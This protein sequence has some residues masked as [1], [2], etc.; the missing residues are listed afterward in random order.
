MYHDFSTHISRSSSFK[1]LSNNRIMN[2]QMCTY[3]H[4]IYIVSLNPWNST[5]D[6]LKSTS[7]CVIVIDRTFGSAEL[8]GRTSAVRFGPND[9]TFF[10]RTQNLFFCI[11]FN[12]NGIL[13]YFCFAKWATCTWSLDK[14]AKR[15]Q[16]E[17]KLEWNYH[18]NLK[19][20]VCLLD[21]GFTP[22]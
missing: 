4:F 15:M 2:G 18:I 13:S 21:L 8:F 3:F 22:N 9:R 12:A 17:P 5:W 1:K 7:Y 11:K 6:N 14:I 10:C 20:F 16:M 19:F